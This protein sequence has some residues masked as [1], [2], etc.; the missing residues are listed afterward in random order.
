MS[1]YLTHAENSDLQTGPADQIAYIHFARCSHRHS[2]SSLGPSLRCTMTT[3]GAP[4]GP[5]SSPP[6]PGVPYA[7]DALRIVEHGDAN[8]SMPTIDA[9]RR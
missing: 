9:T 1:P 8:N 3:V 7:S 6:L 5:P 4:A 2:H